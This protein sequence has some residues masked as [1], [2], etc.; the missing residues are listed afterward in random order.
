MSKKIFNPNRQKDLLNK[1]VN[2]ACLSLPESE[3]GIHMISLEGLVWNLF[4]G[5]YEFSLQDVK[6]VIEQKLEADKI[7]T[8]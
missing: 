6:Y 4:K 5:K 1:L 3:R 2:D 8:K 7:Q